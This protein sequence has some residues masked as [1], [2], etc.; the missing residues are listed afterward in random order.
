[1]SAWQAYNYLGRLLYPF[2]ILAQHKTSV[3]PVEIPRCHRS[4]GNNL[5]STKQHRAGQGWLLSLP[6]PCHTQEVS[7]SFPG[8]MT[9]SQKCCPDFLS[10]R[11]TFFPAPLHNALLLL[12]SMVLFFT[13][14]AFGTRA[15]PC[16]CCS[17]H[18]SCG[19]QSWWFPHCCGWAAGTQ[20]VILCLAAL[21]PAWG[22]TLNKRFPLGWWVSW[23]TMIFGTELCCVYMRAGT[24]E[25][26]LCLLFS[27]C[28]P[29]FSPAFSTISSPF[30]PA[31]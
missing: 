22:A 12:H 24:Y 5:C 8:V 31:C 27:F 9:R 23:Q 4:Y 19:W 26:I 21:L 17:L 18:P 20:E 30:L 28:C 7:P 1:M 11:P 25:Y 15:E 3:S 16:S 2:K 29:F 14:W 10:T 6:A 13:V